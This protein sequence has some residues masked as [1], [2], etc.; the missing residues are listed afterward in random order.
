[1][2]VNFNKN[3]FIKRYIREQEQPKDIIN[4]FFLLKDMID[5]WCNI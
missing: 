3:N 1:M 4:Y 5:K 2:I